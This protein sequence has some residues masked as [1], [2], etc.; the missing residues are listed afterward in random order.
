MYDALMSAVGYLL[1]VL[2]ALQN[3]AATI[4]PK[5]FSIRMSFVTCVGDRFDT[6]TGMYQRSLGTGEEASAKFTLAETELRQLFDAIVDA[7][8][9]DLP[10]TFELPANQ[11]GQVVVMFTVPNTTFEMEVRTSG[12]SHTVRYNDGNSRLEADP[13]VQRFMILWRTVFAMI[14]EKPAVQQLPAFKV[15]C[16]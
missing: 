6:A 7:R 13:R 4:R 1:L 15:G 3:P 16:L 12:T 2:L 14:K 8:F 11:D 10:E 5:D 9:S